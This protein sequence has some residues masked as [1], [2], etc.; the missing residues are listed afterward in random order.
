MGMYTE[1]NVAIDFSK[2]TPAY[3]IVI[4]KAMLGENDN[5]NN[6]ISI[7]TSI[8]THPLFTT[9]NWH[10]MLRCASCY[11]SGFSDSKIRWDSYNEMWQMNIR[12]NLKNYTN[13]IEHFL[14]FIAP[15]LSTEGFIG[16]MRY[17]TDATP[18]LIFRD[19]QTGKIILRQPESYI[20]KSLDDIIN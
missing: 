9:E 17:E 16:Y 13:E 15:Y 18:T 10:I 11:F 12:C 4:V 7:P 8:A 3:I 5:E 20:E 14:S 2:E 1:L 6:N 19:H